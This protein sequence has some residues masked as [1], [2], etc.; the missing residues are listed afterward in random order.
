MCFLFAFSYGVDLL[1]ICGGILVIAVT[2]GD[3]GVGR[4]LCTGEAR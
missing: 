4:E 2:D 1:F 3:G